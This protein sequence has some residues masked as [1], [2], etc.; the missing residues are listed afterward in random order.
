MRRLRELAGRTPAR[1]ERYVDLLRAVAIT[2][3]V[4]GHWLI[5]V[6]DHD[7]SGRLR[8]HNAL[9]E[10]VRARPGTWLFQ[11]M[12]LF[13]LVGGYANAASLEAYRRRGAG[14][15]DWLCDRS[16]RAAR[17]LERRGFHD[18]F[19]YAAGR[20]D[21]LSA[22]LPYVGTANLVSR[23]VRHDPVIASAGDAV[24]GVEPRVVADPA[25]V[26]V[27]VGERDVVLG[28]I[29]DQELKGASPDARAE[30][31]MR[32][33]IPTV[34]PS[35]EVATLCDRMDRQALHEVVVT[36]PDGRLVGVVSAGAVHSPGSESDE[37]RTG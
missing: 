14:G 32:I 25:G 31:I 36:M 33:D 24:S 4:V 10:L 8:G 37:V 18:V 12:P 30:E 15:G 23:I 17:L 6:I 29:G 21:W 28:L 26:A 7:P 16:G 5:V 9:E 13:F 35:E 22:D 11:V 2:M 27:V 1:R 19:D 20:M 3:V 34:R